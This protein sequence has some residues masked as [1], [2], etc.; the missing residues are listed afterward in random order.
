MTIVVQPRWGWIVR[1]VSH[2]RVSLRY[3]HGYSRWF[4]PVTVRTTPNTGII[5]VAA[6][7]LLRFPRDRE[8]P[9]HRDNSIFPWKRRMPSC[10][11]KGNPNVCVTFVCRTL[12]E[13]RVV[14]RCF[15]CR[16]GRP[17]T[18]CPAQ[19]Q[20]VQEQLLYQYSSPSRLLDSSGK[21][22]AG[23]AALPESHYV[24]FTTGLYPMPSHCPVKK[25][26]SGLEADAVDDSSPSPAS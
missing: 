3:T 18:A 21:S 22:S 4:P 13:R 14:K 25:P 12:F 15:P 6:A 5:P 1:D 23:A 17:Q 24:P 26:V 7:L 11:Y 16:T 20:A 8:L 10:G 19:D 9:L 2:P